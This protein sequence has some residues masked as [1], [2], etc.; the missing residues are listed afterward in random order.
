[1]AR[2][3]GLT[4][5]DLLAHLRGEN[6]PEAAA[7]IEAAAAADPDL[8]A[9]LALM[10]ELKP[11]L[12]DATDAPDMRPF[13]W[14]RLE[15]EIAN[16][17]RVAPVDRTPLWRGAAVFLGALVLVQGAYIAFTPGDAEDPAFRTVS[18]EA[19]AFGLG[20]GF[21]ASAEIGAVEALLRETGAR[22][23]DG[24]GALGL[25]RL[26]YESTSAREAARIALAASPLVELV[27]E[28]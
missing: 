8:R 13:G 1:M 21:T 25:Y 7:R 5:D 18:D 11:A 20:V 23:V 12:A 28:E 6:T 27:A 17:P 24:P 2:P 4:E 10:A 15:A 14:R 26:A 19:A 9:E 16:A 22:I 3:D